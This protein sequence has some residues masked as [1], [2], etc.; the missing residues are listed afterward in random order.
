MVSSGKKSSSP[1]MQDQDLDPESITE[2]ASHE[3]S[4]RV[5]PDVDRCQ[6]GE[7]LSLPRVPTLKTVAHVPHRY[8]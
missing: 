8:H 1:H 7:K 3:V 6:M 5:G 2:K 4:C